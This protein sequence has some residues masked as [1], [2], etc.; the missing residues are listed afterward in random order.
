MPKID[1]TENANNATIPAESFVDNDDK[2]F[3]WIWV[4]KHPCSE[5]FEK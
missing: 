4:S 3:I 1:E 5:S 2:V